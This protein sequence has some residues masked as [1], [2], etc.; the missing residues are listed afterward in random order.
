MLERSVTSSAQERAVRQGR[1]RVRRST[2]VRDEGVRAAPARGWH[3]Q[4]L[5]VSL[6]E[7]SA[8][9]SPGKRQLQAW[10]FPQEPRRPP[11]DLLTLFV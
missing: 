10:S 3:A 9:G 1:A 7:R 2:T 4:P 8:P 6:G 5:H 11:V